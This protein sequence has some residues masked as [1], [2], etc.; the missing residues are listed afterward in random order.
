[1]LE[2]TD[3][4]AGYGETIVLRH[5]DLTVPDGRVV[6][7]LGPN[8]AGKTT[9][10]RAASGLLRPNQGHVLLDG[11]DVTRKRAFE[12]T[13]M[14][15]CLI[16]EGRGIYPSLTVAENLTLHSYARDAGSLERAMTAFPVLG[17]KRKQ[18]AGDLSGGQQQMLALARAYI[19]NP[20]LVLVDEASMGLAP[21]LVDEIFSFLTRLAAE[22]TSLLIVEQYVSRALAVADYVYLLNKG[23]VVLSGLPD[24]ISDDVF[25]HYLG[26]AAG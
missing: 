8:G 7:L 2:L 20:S 11:R 22:G 15:L 6:A 3:I 21:V 17:Q 24:E 5:V 19:Q 14:G 9:L 4:E 23:T 16:P 25:S 26:A 12:R 18:L 1:V 13:R 10:L